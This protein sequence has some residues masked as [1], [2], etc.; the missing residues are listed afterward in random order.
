MIE[1]LAEAS[2]ALPE[3][4]YLRIREHPSAG[5]SFSDRIAQMTGQSVILNITRRTLDQVENAQA[6]S[7][8]N[9]SLGFES[10]FLRIPG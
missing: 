8:V 1:R 10:I 2:A 4:W 9:S 3:G 7:T 5:V 6:V